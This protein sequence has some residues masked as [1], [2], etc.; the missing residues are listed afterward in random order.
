[1]FS[2]VCR[3]HC[4]HSFFSF[5]FL[6]FID[7]S[8]LF[9]EWILSDEEKR[10]I[11][12]KIMRNR[13]RRQQQELEA[14]QQTSSTSPNSASSASTLS[15]ST[16]SGG[17]K[18]KR[19]V[20]GKHQSP[21]SVAH[22]TG[23][24]AANPAA[25]GRRRLTASK[26]NFLP[27]GKAAAYRNR[28]SGN[29]G[30][31]ESSNSSSSA[32]TTAT[33][34][35]NSHLY[36]TLNT[37]VF[38]AG[39]ATQVPQTSDAASEFGSS[40]ST[41]FS[42]TAA[43]LNAFNIFQEPSAYSLD[44]LLSDNCDA[45]FD[46]TL[47]GGGSNTGN[48]YII[49]QQH[50]QQNTVL[51]DEWLYS[52]T[53]N[54]SSTAGTLSQSEAKKDD[55]VQSL[56]GAV[57]EID[58]SLNTALNDCL[59]FVG[60]TSSM[61]LFEND[62]DLDGLE[63]FS[64]SSSGISECNESSNHESPMYDSSQTA[65]LVSN[66][67]T[68]AGHP[69]GSIVTDIADIKN[70]L[71]ELG[72]SNAGGGGGGTSSHI[73]TSVTTGSNSTFEY[74]AVKTETHDFT[75]Y[76]LHDNDPTFN[77]AATGS[78][79]NNTSNS[80]S[81]NQNNNNNNTL[82][83]IT[84]GG[85]SGS[86][87]QQSNKVTAAHFPSLNNNLTAV[88]SINHNHNNPNLNNHNNSNQQQSMA[89]V[90]KSYN[91]SA[92]PNSWESGGNQNNALQVANVRYMAADG[93]VYA[94]NRSK[95]PPLVKMAPPPS[96]PHPPLTALPPPN[97]EANDFISNCLIS[98]ND[99]SDEACNYDP[100]IEDVPRIGTNEVMLREIGFSNRELILPERCL[101][102]ELTEACSVLKNPYKR[103]LVFNNYDSVRS[104]RITEY[105]FHRLIRCAKRLSRFSMLPLGDQA[106]MLKYSLLEMLAM[107]SVLSYN[108]DRESW[109]FID[110][111]FF[112]G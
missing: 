40:A 12:E 90:Q 27:S 64:G 108:P 63:A 66:S 112:I 89:L 35:N 65:V 34:G 62:N 111:S 46:P 57:S 92:Q 8:L 91:F 58:E 9:Q 93:G 100:V 54:T 25:G 23:A 31:F 105:S 48:Q 110:V 50:Q 37:S 87:Q 38:S 107:R 55:F 72:N 6:S 3:H 36:S 1:M 15:S 2:F 45:F 68:S 81:N 83:G 11:K 99:H 103:I 16:G 59:L 32:T 75:Q 13:L 85:H 30:G 104:C 39:G 22:K 61:D 41:K 49:S 70:E 94:G 44:I 71:Q 53:G 21:I 18:G 82:E 20:E 47:G 17:G 80:G 69:V 101:I 98:N 26:A 97:P 84:H 14:Q 106:K 74:S 76:L 77:L 60:D 73:I 7:H 102:K 43:A 52:S 78:T 95:V 67:S 56:A 5:S 96:L 24:A 4:S 10:L 79:A 109:G 88:Q 28:S 33:S 86:Q 51:H 19:S 29:G 42:G